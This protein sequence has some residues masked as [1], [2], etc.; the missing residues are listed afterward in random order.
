MEV[1]AKA[2]NLGLYVSLGRIQLVQIPRDRLD[3]GGLLLLRCAH[4]SLQLL[5]FTHDFAQ[6]FL[7]V[8]TFQYEK[9]HHATQS[10]NENEENN[11]RD[12]RKHVQPS[13]AQSIS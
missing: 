6:A 2:V 10:Q 9:S 13:A 11:Y 1:A 7:V 12:R 4:L 3:H 5:L 8:R